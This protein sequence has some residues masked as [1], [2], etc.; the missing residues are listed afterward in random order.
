MP[1]PILVADSNREFGI[2]I[3]QALEESGRFEVS[4]ASSA[5]EAVSLAKDLDFRLAI[6]DFA[7][8]DL[9]GEQ[10]VGRIRALQPGLAVIAIPVSDEDNASQFDRAAVDGLLTKP[11]YLPNLPAIVEQALGSRLDFHRQPSPRPSPPP[12]AP[13][14]SQTGPLAE[15]TPEGTGT[16]EGSPDSLPP[17]LSDVDRAAKYLARLTLETS[18][19]AALLIRHRELVAFAGQLPRSQLQELTAQAADCW[20]EE[21]RT[22]AVARFV[23]LPGT[24]EDFM[25]Y[26]TG[27]VT[28]LVLSLV[29]SAEVPFGM[30]R[31]QAEAFAHALSEVDPSHQTSVNVEEGN[32]VAGERP[33]PDSTFTA[34]EVSPE[35]A[36]QQTLSPFKDEP[37]AFTPADDQPL[38]EDWI[39]R[40]EQPSASSRLLEELVDLELPEPDPGEGPAGHRPSQEKTHR[41]QT[42]D[43]PLDWL[44]MITHSR[45]H[46][47][48]LDEPDQV[49][50]ETCDATQP[51]TASEPIPVSEA[52]QAVA[53]VA[54]NPEPE[55]KPPVDIAPPP[56]VSPSIE[57]A[58]PAADVLPSTSEPDHRLP[59]SIVLAP[60]FPEHRLA[61]PLVENLA[62]WTRRLC[63]AWDWKA[64]RVDVTDDALLIQLLLPPDVAPA[65]AVESLADHLSERILETF[66]HLRPGFPSGRFWAS[67]H[68]LA[69]GREIVP[70]EMQSFVRQLR[71]AQGL[72][73]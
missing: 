50:G 65:A 13:S 19:E 24:V 44:P 6:I 61:G 3:R 26:A 66:P 72:A 20:A 63:I 55:P 52:P 35:P 11:F 22:G 10:I 15:K 57:A 48:F 42:P 56:V 46:L 27:V 73:D 14:P 38:P 45:R 43:L 41:P 49:E 53:P 70:A 40:P 9:D 71:Q 30:I 69:A 54:Q 25:L 12:S 59:F 58:P 18:A 23:H 7:L 8:P 34:R 37:E 5:E 31:R 64:E 4:L 60:R 28:D 32:G 36:V 17:W 51:E 16:G 67:P 2:L 33:A 62:Q 39:P 47:P 21:G 1:I 29:F 68:L